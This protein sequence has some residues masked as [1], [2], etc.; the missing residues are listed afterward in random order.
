LAFAACA[1]LPLFA[2][3]AYAAEES[4]DA[5]RERL[6]LLEQMRRQEREQ[7]G[8]NRERADEIA[9]Q[10]SDIRAQAIGFARSAQAAEAALSEIESRLE[11]LRREAGEA[12]TVLA[13]RDERAREVA[14]ALL[15]LART[16]KGQLLAVRGEPV[17]VLRASLL[18][19]RTIPALEIEAETAR[20]ELATLGVT[21][22]KLVEEMF[23][24]ARAIERLSEDRAQ[25][26]SLLDR[27][28]SLGDAAAAAAIENA[29][30]LERLAEEAADLSALIDRIGAE[31]RKRAEQ[32]VAGLTTRPALRPWS[33]ARSIARFPAEGR[34]V[35]DFGQATDRGA[36]RGITFET[37]RGATVVAPFDGDVAFAGPFRNY[38]LILIV[39][40][41]EGYHSLLIG[42][43]RIDA[44]VGQKL[45]AGEPV[46]KM[47]EGDR[48]RLYIELRRGGQPINPRPW[49][50]AEESK[51]K[52]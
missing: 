22:A 37:R 19:G 47:G 3:P 18:L 33:A 51:V 11:S 25:L 49:F 43:D 15:R 8:I 6:R 4:V 13:T 35:V 29:R 52:G 20:K 42:M 2:A 45:V 36:N 23:A 26:R 48:P 21:R 9:A 46:G 44:S 30:G 28:A 39:D 34:I 16:P 32:T 12:E 14:V 40:H 10:L 17:D 1:A 31:E 38:G 24:H 50:T 7:E 5:L 27:K 41:A